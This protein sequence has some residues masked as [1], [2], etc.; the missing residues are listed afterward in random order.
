MGG[1][2]V[3]LGDRVMD[4]R[5]LGPWRQAPTGA[6]SRARLGRVS[7][8]GCQPVVDAASRCAMP[9]MHDREGAPKLEQ[10]QGEQ[11][12]RSDARVPPVKA[13]VGR[14]HVRRTVTMST[15]GGSAAASRGVGRAEIL[16]CERSQSVVAPCPIECPVVRLRGG[17]AFAGVGLRRSCGCAAAVGTASATSARPSTAE[18]VSR[19]WRMGDASWS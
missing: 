14:L 2:T 11:D 1:S 7:E 8:T 19:W 13:G 10:D 3:G 16:P 4:V 18:R 17:G 9:A 12:R 15:D 5:V 6:R